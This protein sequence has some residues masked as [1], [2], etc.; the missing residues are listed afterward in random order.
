MVKGRLAVDEADACQLA[1]LMCQIQYRDFDQA[2]CSHPSF[3]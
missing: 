2:E 1:A 3:E